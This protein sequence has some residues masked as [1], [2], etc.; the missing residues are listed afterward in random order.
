MAP[1]TYMPTRPSTT[2]TKSRTLRVA[3]SWRRIGTGRQ[4][5]DR[6]VD[7][8]D[9]NRGDT[10]TPTGQSKTVGGG[11]RD[12]H[13][14]AERCGQDILRL[15]T[16]RS[17]SW[18]ITDHLY[19]CVDDR[20]P[21]SAH[22]GSSMR[23]QRDTGR[24]S[25]LRVIGPDQRAQITE[26][27]CRQNGIAD[28]MRSHIGIGVTGQAFLALPQQP[29]HPH[30]STRGKGMDIRPYADPHTRLPVVHRLYRTRRL[31]ITASASTMSI[32]LVTLKDS[33]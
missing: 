20:E 16:S 14:S 15:L 30:R 3:V 13:W 9:G 26:A 5:R 21:T 33:S 2:G 6:S 23:D 12:T 28:R 18:T 27:S 31:A 7:E 29:R 25:P 32:G 10:F 1:H 19:R 4:Y 8:G 17:D 22:R 11:T 24:V